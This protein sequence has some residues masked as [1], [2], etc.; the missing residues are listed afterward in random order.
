MLAIPTD[1][2][3]SHLDPRARDGRRRVDASRDVWLNAGLV[4]DLEDVTDS[5]VAMPRSR[6]SRT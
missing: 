6:I 4:A 2:D 1:T 5:G 3:V